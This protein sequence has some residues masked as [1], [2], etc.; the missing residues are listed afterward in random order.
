MLITYGRVPL[1]YYV[2]HFA[3][4]H[5]LAAGASYLRF[6]QEFGEWHP[7]LVAPFPRQDSALLRLYAEAQALIVR[8]P[9]A[10][11]AA[12]GDTVLLLRLD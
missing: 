6:R 4:I 5:G 12:A 3:L 8:P 1:F 11:A 10:P 2:L 9:A 7:P